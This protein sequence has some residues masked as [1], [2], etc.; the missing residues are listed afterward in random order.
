MILTHMNNA[1]YLREVD[2][3]R[4]DFYIRTSLYDVVRSQKGQILLGAC[5]VRFRRF[6][7]IF[8]RFKITTKILYW[9]DENIFIEHKV[10]TFDLLFAVYLKQFLSS[11]V[12]RQR[13][14]YSLHFA[15][16]AT[17]SQL[18]RRDSNGHSPQTRKHN[19]DET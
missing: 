16:S 1:R 18:F 6:I 14:V 9:N 11:L 5:N 19:V 2:M 3:A 4:I 17:S 15:L 12:C 13:W 10:R 8:Q 7:G